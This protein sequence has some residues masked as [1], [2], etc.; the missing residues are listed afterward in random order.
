MTEEASL[1]HQVLHSLKWVTLGKIL[2][3]LVRWVITFWVIRLLTPEDY[4]LVSMA[5]IYFGFL[6][7]IVSQLFGP[8]I[9]QSKSLDNSTLSSLF[10]TILITHFSIFALQYLTADLVAA[11]YES[12]QVAD[13]LRVNAWCFLIL[14]FNTIPAA[15]LAKK[16]RFKAVSL[17]AAVANIVAAISTLAMAMYGLGFWSLIYGEIISITL[18][19]LATL[20]VQPIPCRPSF[21]LAKSVELIKFGGALGALSMLMYVFLHMDIAI[22]GSQLTAEEIG[23]FAIGLQFA[24]MPQKKILPLIKQVAF[25]AF[26]KIQDKPTQ[27]A[28]YVLK[29]QRLSLLITIPIFWGLASV[30][31]LII[32]IILGEK[33]I[34]AIIP[35]TL[36]LIIMPLRFSDELFNPALKSQKKV[37]HLLINTSIMI[38]VMFVAIL[39]GVQYGA[40]GLA[41]AW[42]FG[43]PVVYLINAWRNIHSLQIKL[44]EFVAV[45]T[46]PL[47]VG[48]AMLA[49]VFATKAVFDEVNVENLLL[50]ILI[51]GITFIGLLFMADKKAILEIKS[52]R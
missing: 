13:I 16:M 50:Q 38:S 40:V 2:T 26:S 19:T 25:P 22:A 7:L 30:V 36:I 14:A 27:I 18:A 39:I 45:F 1:K 34:S 31:D 23:L 24:L 9:I 29:A 5:D 4:G 42:C 44:K 6:T 28:H 12:D 21:K 3:Q 41:L 11:Y 15:L 49:V 47:L 8:A 33:W 37:R 52:L 46:S 51:G 17:I 10:G 48:T 43:F 20:Y 35:T 32:P